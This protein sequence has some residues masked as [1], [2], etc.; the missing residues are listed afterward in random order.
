MGSYFY[1]HGDSPGASLLW[2]PACGQSYRPSSHTRKTMKTRA[3]CPSAG[4]SRHIL[5]VLGRETPW[6]FMI[7]GTALKLPIVTQISNVPSNPERIQ[8]PPP[9][10]ENSNSA[11]AHPPLFCN[12]QASAFQ[13]KNGDPLIHGENQSSRSWPVYMY[14]Y[15]ICKFFLCLFAFTRAAPTAYGGSQARGLIEAV[16]TDL[17]QSHSNTGSEPCLQPMPQLTATP[18]P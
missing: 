6:L 2:S 14:L 3:E 18:D 13:T 11:P 16:A 8:N 10:P 5:A 7:L 17:R 1:N 9:T 12:L 15:I 4:V